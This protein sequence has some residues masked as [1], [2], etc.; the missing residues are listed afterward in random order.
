MKRAVLISTLV[1]VLVFCWSMACAEDAFFVIVGKKRNYAPVEKSGVTKW[2]N[3]DGDETACSGTGQDGEY[4]KGIAWPSPRFTDN[5]DGTVTD[6]L[7]GL[8]WLKDA[9]CIKSNYPEFDCDDT[10]GDGKVI[11]QH[12]LDFVSGIN[13]GTYPN[14]GGGHTDWRLPNV[15]EL[16]SLIDFSSVNPA[17]PNA[18]GTGQWTEG[19]P[20]SNVL[21]YVYWS[22]TTRAQSYCQ[23]AWKVTIADGSTTATDK[24]D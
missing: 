22:S 14:C 24:S 16:H 23:S 19:D 21:P 13:D 4:Q 6:N 11:W 15:R 10:Y 9:N 8:I 1:L 12:E 17:V 2:Y 20:F 18:A 3:S 5:G 7:T